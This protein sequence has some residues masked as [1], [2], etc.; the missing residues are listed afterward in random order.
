MQ[1]SHVGPRFGSVGGGLKAEGEDGRDRRKR[2][3]IAHPVST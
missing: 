2:I 1:F 3:G